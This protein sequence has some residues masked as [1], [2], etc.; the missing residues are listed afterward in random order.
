VI[1]D[2]DA[3]GTV[4]V[5]FTCNQAG[6]EG[7]LWVAFYNEDGILVRLDR[8]MKE[9]FEVSKYSAVLDYK[10]CPTAASIKVSI[11]NFDTL[12]PLCESAE[13]EIKK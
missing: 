13:Y 9:R 2:G 12:T 4:N 6:D 1:T 8:A 11:W 7:E 10:N 5:E 3:E